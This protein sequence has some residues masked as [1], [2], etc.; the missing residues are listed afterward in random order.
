MQRLKSEQYFTASKAITDS[1]KIITLELNTDRRQSKH[2]RYQLSF[3]CQ[4]KDGALYESY[5]TTVVNVKIKST[6]YVVQCWYLTI[7][8]RAKTTSTITHN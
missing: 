2:T 1:D 6:R 3:R 5:K 4:R 7:T 8:M